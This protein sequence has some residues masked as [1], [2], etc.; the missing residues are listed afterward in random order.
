MKTTDKPRCM[1]FPFPCNDVGDNIVILLRQ[2]SDNTVLP[3]GKLY[4]CD[5]CY[6]ELRRHYEH[7]GK[8]IEHAPVPL[9]A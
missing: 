8:L 7:T 3:A 5:S 4:Y 1:G 6:S 9:A 2:L